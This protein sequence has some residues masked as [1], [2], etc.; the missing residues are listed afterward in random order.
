MAAGNTMSWY[1]DYRGQHTGWTI[2]ATPS[3]PEC[4]S[5]FPSSA[6]SVVAMARAT[7][8]R[9]STT[10]AR[11]RSTTRPTRASTRRRRR[12]RRR[13]S[14]AGGAAD[15]A[16]VAADDPAAVGHV[17]DHLLLPVGRVPH[18]D[19]PPALRHRG[20]RQYGNNER[21]TITA[22]RDM[23]VHAEAD[24][25]TE[26]GWDYL[27]INGATFSGT[28]GPADIVLATGDTITWRSDFSGTRGGWTICGHHL[29]PPVSPPP[30]PPPAIP[31]ASCDAG[32]SCGMC[33]MLVSGQPARRC[34]DGC[35]ARRRAAMRQTAVRSQRSTLTRCSISFSTS[36]TSPPC[37][38]LRPS[39]PPHRLRRWRTWRRRRY[40]HL[41]HSAQTAQTA[42]RASTPLR[43]PRAR[44]PRSLATCAS[45]PRRRPAASTAP[46]SAVAPRRRRS[47]STRSLYATIS[48]PP[49]EPPSPPSIPPS[50]PPPA[51]PGGAT[52]AADAADAAG[53]A[54]GAP[55]S[56]RRMLS[57]M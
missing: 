12:R 29:S 27:T 40:E 33:F 35:C 57:A 38:R 9:P 17:D 14:P 42:A 52:I 2:C 34:P 49:P 11:R 37:R 20:R 53:A 30:A 1:S 32:Q 48:P 18:N 5:T 47:P 44:R 8:T 45:R 3:I 23:I 24:Y 22:A 43:S 46:L 7:P 31:L 28:A 50:T 26:S 39:L 54:A 36:P 21:C 10:A 41:V 19:P 51:P 56:P 15:A 55:P 25:N 13:P 16:D 6:S 4:S